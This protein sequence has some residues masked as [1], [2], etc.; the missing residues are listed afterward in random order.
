MTEVKPGNETSEHKLVTLSVELFDSKRAANV[1]YC[2]SYDPNPPAPKPLVVLPCADNITESMANASDPT[3]HSRQ[4]F[5]YLSE[6]GVLSLLWY[7]PNASPSVN[8]ASQAPVDRRHLSA[9]AASDDGSGSSSYG[10]VQNVTLV[11]T[12]TGPAVRAVQ[13]PLDVA[14]FEPLDG[15]NSST[16][17]ENST[18]SANAT[19]SPNATESAYA[20]SSS[21]PMSAMSDSSTPSAAPSPS[22]NASSTSVVSMFRAHVA[23]IYAVADESEVPTGMSSTVTTPFTGDSFTSTTDA[24]SDVATASVTPSASASAGSGTADPNVQVD[25]NSQ[26]SNSESE[27]A[28]EPGASTETSPTSSGVMQ[29]QEADVRVPPTDVP[30]SAS[31]ASSTTEA[32][33]MGTSTVTV[34]VTES[35]SE[36]PSSTASMSASVSMSDGGATAETL[37]VERMY[38]PSV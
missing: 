5:E 34:T 30:A 20:Y 38:R 13:S 16:T 2:V 7:S 11:F 31:Q 14:A 1:L 33:S 19:I 36:M 37:S 9:R 24:A 8:S 15:N 32:M 25:S 23:T 29:M 28:T 6:T 4:I 17:S 22:P 26:T 21:T 18:A 12:P 27:S 35:G 10:K 3:A